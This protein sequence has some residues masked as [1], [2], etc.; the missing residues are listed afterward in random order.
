MAPTDEESWYVEHGEYWNPT[1][2]E[3]MSRLSDR[4][5]ELVDR[6]AWIESEIQRSRTPITQLLYWWSGNGSEGARDKIEKAVTEERMQEVINE[7]VKKVL[8]EQ[9]DQRKS[10]RFR[11]HDFIVGAGM[12]LIAA[13]EVFL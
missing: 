12:L 4:L 7:T 8:E 10:N 2:M 13:L 3:R 9:Q 11:R 6:I 5:K 1:I